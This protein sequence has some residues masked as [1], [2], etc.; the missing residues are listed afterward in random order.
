MVDKYI[1]LSH[2]DFVF[3]DSVSKGKVDNEKLNQL[4]ADNP[5]TAFIF[6]FHSTKSGGL[7]DYTMAFSDFNSLILFLSM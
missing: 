6:I 4:I 7:L 3:I 5:K 2:F 1:N